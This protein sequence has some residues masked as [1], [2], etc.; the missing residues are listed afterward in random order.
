MVKNKSR[1]IYLNSFNEL[2]TGDKIIAPG[3][4]NQ[5][6]EYLIGPDGTGYL[7]ND[8][9][10]YPAYQFAPNEYCRYN[11]ELNVGEFDNNY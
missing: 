9:S 1:Y 2:N 3:I 6:M 5:I 7:V 10:A 8:I 11:G 4:D